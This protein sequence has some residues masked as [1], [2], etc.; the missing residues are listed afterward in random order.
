[1]TKIW[2]IQKERCDRVFEKNYKTS[3]QLALEIQRHVH[4]WNTDRYKIHTRASIH[5]KRSNISWGLPNSSQYKINFD[6]AWLSTDSPAGYV[7][8]LCNNTRTFEQGQAGPFT[9]LSS[10]E[11]E[12]IGFLQAAKWAREKGIFALKETAKISLII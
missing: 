10:E 3:L 11:A 6:A 7:I 12:A 8:I 1:M 5:M 2:F 9:T 4:Y